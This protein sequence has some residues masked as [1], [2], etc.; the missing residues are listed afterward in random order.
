MAVIEGQIEPLKKLKETLEQNGIT[1]FGSI[2]EIN[3][4]IKN[5][6]TEKNEIPKVIEHEFDIEINQLR[7]D[8]SKCQQDYD[9]L[10]ASVTNEI[11][12]EIENLEE[13]LAVIKKRVN[14]N[15][16]YKIFFHS[17]EKKLIK[18]ISKFEKNFKSLVD[19]GA[20]S[21][22][23]DI[24]R[25]KRKLDDYTQNRAELSSERCLQV[26]RELERTKDVI[27]GLYNLIAGAIGE[28]S[29]I[30][31]I[32]K[33]PDNFHLFNDFSVEFDPPIYN[34]KEDDRIYSIQ[35]D[36][37]LVCEA[38]I[39]ILETKNWGKQSVKSIDLR[40]PVKQIMRSSYALFVLLNSQSRHNIN[41]ES[42]HW[43]SKQIPVKNLIVMTNAKP[44][45]EFKHV[46]ILSLKELN[47]YVTYFDPVFNSTEIGSICD[48]LRMRMS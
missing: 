3:D 29:V 37:L 32:Q 8:L 20:Q 35:I 27:D 45:E 33:L 5:Y 36:H 31:E 44:R 11:N 1:R 4:F 16:I 19:K 7:I 47:G 13:E 6:E 18:K 21:A 26:S 9:A 10:K 43:G 25:V 40:S 34:K 24:Y 41:L 2:G 23:Q 46:K 12:I 30:K 28:N 17:K 42:H 39:F 38:G 22:Q 15:F 14:R 48:Y